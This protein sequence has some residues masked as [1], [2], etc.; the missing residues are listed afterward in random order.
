MAAKKPGEETEG[1]S[2]R[3]CVTAQ[4]APHKFFPLH[5]RTPEKPA[6]EAASRAGMWSIPLAG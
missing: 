5:P 4:E 6:L 3:S 2:H 1:E